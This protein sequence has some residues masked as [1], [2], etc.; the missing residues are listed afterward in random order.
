MGEIEE[1]RR[2]FEA[3]LARA[4]P[5]GLFAEEIEPRGGEQRGNFPQALTLLAVVNAAVALER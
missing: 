5:L 4:T 2:L 1:A 3:L